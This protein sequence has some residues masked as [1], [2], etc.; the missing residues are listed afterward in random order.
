MVKRFPPGEHDWLALAPG[1]SLGA[2][3]DIGEAWDVSRAGEYSLQFGNDIQYRVAASSETLFVAAKD[4]GT[5]NFTV[6][7]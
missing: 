7:N 6:I 4:C 1:A 5:V 2:S 3:T